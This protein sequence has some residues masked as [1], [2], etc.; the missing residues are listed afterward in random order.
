MGSSAVTA[1]RAVTDRGA[2]AGTRRGLGREESL[3]PLLW[4]G[5]ACSEFATLLAAE[6][7]FNLNSIHSPT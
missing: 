2:A 7:V 5:G 3:F 6:Y 1:G 4:S